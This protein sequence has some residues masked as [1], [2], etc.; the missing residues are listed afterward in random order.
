MIIEKADDRDGEIIYR[1]HETGLYIQG[2]EERLVYHSIHSGK[3]QNPLKL[4]YKA[5]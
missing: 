1:R 5:K 4:D 2:P 3:Q